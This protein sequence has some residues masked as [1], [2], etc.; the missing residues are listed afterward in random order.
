MIVQA[1]K[2]TVGGVLRPFPVTFMPRQRHV[3]KT[4]SGVREPRTAARCCTGLIFSASI[5]R[6]PSRCCRASD[7][8][9]LD[10]H[11]S[12]MRG[13][14]TANTVFEIPV[15]GATRLDPQIQTVRIGDFKGFIRRLEGADFCVGK[16]IYG[17]HSII[18][19]NLTPDLTTN[20]S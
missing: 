6:I 14:F 9:W 8:R 10:R 19:T 11:S 4:F 5:L 1:G 2:Q 16:G 3:L 18:R 15:V 17:G 7:R 20:F 12:A 13:F